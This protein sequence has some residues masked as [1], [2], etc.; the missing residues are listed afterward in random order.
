MYLGSYIHGENGYHPYMTD[1][2]E[3]DYE[4]SLLRMDDNWLNETWAF[5]RAAPPGS[6]GALPMPESGDK[7]YVQECSK[8]PDA[9]WT[10]CKIL[11]DQS[12][13]PLYVTTR[14]NNRPFRLQCHPQTGWTAVHPAGTP[15]KCIGP[16]PGHV[17]QNMIAKTKAFTVPTTFGDKRLPKEEKKSINLRVLMRTSR[18]G[19]NGWYAAVKFAKPLPE[20]VSFTSPEVVKRYMSPDRTMVTFEPKPWKIQTINGA[21]KY[22]Q[23]FKVNRDR[24]W[25]QKLLTS[26]KNGDI[27]IILGDYRWHLYEQSY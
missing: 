27:R 14:D 23:A 21:N 16:C 4:E 19:A 3:V 25:R 8:D 22:T 10:V 5:S 9:I 2:S 12:N 20:D 15:F 26:V 1:Q 17:S 13:P 18:L 11:C 7:A 24:N 6:C